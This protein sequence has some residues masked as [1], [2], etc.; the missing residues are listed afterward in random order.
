VAESF[1]V[2]QGLDGAYDIDLRGVIATHGIECY[3]H[4]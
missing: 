2:L 1:Q 3:L 4:V